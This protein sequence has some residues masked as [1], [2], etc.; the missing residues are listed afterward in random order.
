MQSL[1]SSNPQTSGTL[2]RNYHA[3]DDSATTFNFQQG[4]SPI[5]FGRLENLLIQI[6]NAS[7][8]CNAYVAT[9]GATGNQAGNVYNHLASGTA[10]NISSG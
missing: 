1:Y 9:P 8:G 5:H 10:S 2:I 6:D 7:M 4:A 3:G